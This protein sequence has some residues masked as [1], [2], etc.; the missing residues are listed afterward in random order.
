MFIF[1]LPHTGPAAVVVVGEG[2]VRLS[3]LLNSLGEAKAQLGASRKMLERL[4]AK[5]APVEVPLPRTVAERVTR[6]AGYQST[7]KEVSR[8]VPIVKVWGVG[9]LGFFLRKQWRDVGF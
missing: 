3:D 6:K 7:A 4:D 2:E 1:Q 9:Q 8:W 5:G